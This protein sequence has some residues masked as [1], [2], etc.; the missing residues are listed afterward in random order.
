MKNTV[1]EGIFDCVV[2]VG[3]GVGDIA[4]VAVEAGIGEETRIRTEVV[5][6]RYRVRSSGVKVTDNTWIPRGRIVPAA[7]E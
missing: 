1:A 3:M 5:T 2:F 6:G 4:G 7:G